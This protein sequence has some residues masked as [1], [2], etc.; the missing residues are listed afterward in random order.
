MEDDRE[1]AHQVGTHLLMLQELEYYV[2]KVLQAK[3]RKGQV[4]V[5]KRRKEIEGRR[6][7][8]LTSSSL[9]PPAVPLSLGGG[10]SD[11]FRPPSRDSAIDTRLALPFGAWPDDQ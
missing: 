11:D 5:R 2:T 10:P 4:C 7:S 1:D 3:E 9:S 8:K 6:T